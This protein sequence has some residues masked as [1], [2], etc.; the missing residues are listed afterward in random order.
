MQMRDGSVVSA[1]VFE[2]IAAAIRHGHAF[3]TKRQRQLDLQSAPAGSERWL[4][5]GGD[6]EEIAAGVRG[7]ART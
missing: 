5:R 3:A 2:T 1:G 7:G 6:L 4:W